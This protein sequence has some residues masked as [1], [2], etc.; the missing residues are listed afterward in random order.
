MDPKRGQFVC[1]GC[2]IV[3][4]GIV[5]VY[6]ASITSWPTEFERIYLSRQLEALA[7]GISL[8][9]VCACTPPRFWRRAAPFL[10][11]IT[12]ALLAVVL[13]PKIG[14][15]VNGAR[16]WLRYG[17]FQFQPSELAKLTLVL[18]LSRQAEFF[19]AKPELAT[20]GRQFAWRKFV[21]LIAP[22][23]I[24]A[25]L[26]LMEPD[27]GTAVFL[28][29]IGTMTLFVAGLPTRY[30]LIAGTAALPAAG[31]MALLRPY[32]MRRVTG[33]LAVWSDWSQVPYQLDQSLVSM[34]SGGLFGVGLG[35][36]WQKLSF[37]PEAN[38][39]FVFSVVGEE[40]GLL[41]T[42]GLLLLFAALYWA[43]LRA[44]REIRHDRFASTAAF[45]LLTQLILQASANMTVVTAL[46]PPKGIPLPLVSYG[47]SA[48]V[49]SLGC[50]GIVCSL[51][52][53]EKQPLE[54]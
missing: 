45:V 30:F 5:M 53:S 52:R 35:R 41:G 13:L 32:Q 38:T 6:S 43:G 46:I 37:L 11:A 44:I 40:L 16:R 51:S 27:L 10:M 1:L 20:P 21:L 33:F 42:M 15:R 22:I 9:G 34:G 47:G 4:F 29:L 28:T 31:L 12:I 18:Y 14:T 17:G 39:D 8:V 49:T 25:G 3:G 50:L 48:L 54:A 2:A 36:G 24:A 23:A 19:G 7:V 26:V